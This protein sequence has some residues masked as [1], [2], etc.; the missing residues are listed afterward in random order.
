MEIGGMLDGSIGTTVAPGH[1]RSHFPA[2]FNLKKDWFSYF[3]V[4][5]MGNPEG[6][7]I[8][9]V[10]GPSNTSIGWLSRNQYP[11]YGYDFGNVKLFK[12]ARLPSKLSS[13]TT[14]IVIGCGLDDVKERVFFTRNG[15]FLE[16]FPVPA[17]FSNA[18]KDRPVFPAIRIYR[19]SGL[20]YTNYGHSPFKFA[21]T[22][23]PTMNI[24]RLTT[25]LAPEI[26]AII[27]GHLCDDA[28]SPSI[29][30]TET[31][32][33]INCMRTCRY[34][35]ECIRPALR[36][37]KVL[38]HANYELMLSALAQPESEIAS[39][40]RQLK[41]YEGGHASS[42]GSTWGIRILQA[43]GGA[44]QTPLEV[45]EY[46]KDPSVWNHYLRQHPV[47]TM[48]L[49]HVYAP[50]CNLRILRLQNHRFPSAKDLMRLVEALSV[51]E[52]LH[53]TCVIWGRQPLHPPAIRSSSQ[54]VTIGFERCKGQ[55]VAVWILASPYPRGAP[56]VK[57]G[58]RPALDEL[59]RDY[60]SRIVGA[61]SYLA[62]NVV[63]QWMY[64][65]NSQ[66]WHYTA[67][68]SSTDELGISSRLDISLITEGP[69]EN[70]TVTQMDIVVLELTPHG[71]QD[72]DRLYRLYSTYITLFCQFDWRTVDDALSRVQVQRFVVR[73]SNC[74]AYVDSDETLRAASTYLDRHGLAIYDIDSYK[75]YPNCTF[76]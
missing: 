60:L 63:F 43:L 3:E 24:R 70:A 38:N 54:L 36:Q 27:L 10:P 68:M 29:T 28:R 8:G 62:H 44:G 69:L 17:L 52:A 1:I 16:D 45:L 48:L 32:D 47:L 71:D 66:V 4:K 53:L 25:R 19:Q 61:F 34:W 5:I 74:L 65:G 55:H 39:T 75:G 9:F 20:I 42:S 26:I 21:I 67:D 22:D 41:I 18:R 6:V 7:T 13:Q 51:L 37:T 73:F 2:T 33:L 59:H 23:H 56:I 30:A 49:R 14:G 46:K 58:V 12:K 50:F 57:S 40:V 15:H 64:D 72:S 31:S 35:Y 76:A 11:T